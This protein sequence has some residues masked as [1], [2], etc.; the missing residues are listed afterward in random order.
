M[1]VLPVPL[2]PTAITFFATGRVL[3]TGEFQD[4]GLVERRNR[5]EVEAVE[6][7]DGREPRFLDPTLHHAAFSIDQLQFDEAQEKADMVETF[8]SALPSKLLILAQERR[9]LERLQ[10]MTEKKLG[11]IGHDDAPVSKLM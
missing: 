4:E 3:G 6:A 11:R 9:Q 1:C 8:G 2:L 10:V 5:R 7:F